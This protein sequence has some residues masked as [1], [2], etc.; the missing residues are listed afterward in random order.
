MLH[1]QGRRRRDSNSKPRRNRTRHKYLK[2]RQLCLEELEA[3]AMLTG[4]W[5]P[6]TNLAP[7]APV[8]FALLSDGSVIQPGNGYRLTPDATGS[9]IN[10]TWS[11]SAGFK[12]S[13]RHGASL[14]VLPDGRLMVFGGVTNGTTPTPLGDGE[15]FDAVTGAATNMASFPESGS[16]VGPSV[17]P[18]ML[19]PNGDVL[20]G[21]TSDPN[22]YI[23][24]PV[25][26]AYESWTL[27]PNGSILSYD[28]NGKPGEA[29]RLD[30]TT[31]TWVDAGAVPVALEAGISAYKDMGPGVL[32]PNGQ[33]LQFGRSSQTAIY[34][35]PTPG[36]G[37]NG[38][39]SWA[40][41]PVIPNGLEAGGENPTFAGSAAA[42]LPSGDVLFTADMPD[43]VGPTKFFEWNPTTNSVTDVTPPIASYQSNSANSTI[44]ML[45]LPTGQVLLGNQTDQQLYVYTPGGSPQAAW[46]PTITS[47]VANGDH[48]TLTGTQLNGI[49]AGVSHGVST[50]MATNFPIVE[51]KDSSGVVYLARTSNWSNTGVATGK[52]AMSTDFTLPYY[53]PADT[54]SLTV[55]A[56][57]ISSDPTPFQLVV[58]PAGDF[59]LDEQVTSADVPV[60]LAALSDLNAF[61]QAHTLSAPQLFALGDLNGDHLVNNADLQWLLSKLRGTLVNAVPQM[62]ID[63]DSAA[64]VGS[65]PED[66]LTIGT[67]TYFTAD[68]GIH[69][70]ELWKTDGTAAGTV[71]VKDINPD[72]ES[73][74]PT[75]LTVFN[76]EL[77]FAADDGVDGNELWKSDGTEAGTVMVADIQPGSGYDS[78]SQSFVPYSSNP[79]Y[80]TVAGGT[81]FFAAND[82]SNGVELWKTD[83][84]EQGTVLVKDIDT[85]IGYGSYPS[86][87]TDV[88]GTLFFRAYDSDNGDE[89]WKSDGTEAGTVLVKDIYPG[90]YY[91]TRFKA[92]YPNSSFPY[93]LTAVGGTLYFTAQDG[94]HGWELWESDGTEAGT[95]L[96][97]DIDP[98]PDGFP[99]DLHALNGKL[100]FD[101][102]DGQ[103]GYELWTSDGTAAGTQ[104]VKDIFP[105][106]S[107]GFPGNMRVVNGTLYFTAYQATGT[108]RDAELWKSDGT[109]DGT[110]RIADINPGLGSSFPY[111]F[112]QLGNTIYF[113]ADDGTHGTELWKT[114]GTPAGTTLVCDINPGSPESY[115]VN[116]T[117]L[118]NSLLFTADDGVHGTELW[119]LTPGQTVGGSQV[120]TF[121]NDAESLQTALPGSSSG[122]DAVV[123]SGA[124]QF[125]HRSERKAVNHFDFYRHE[126]AR[127]DQRPQAPSVEPG[128]KSDVATLPI[129]EPT[130]GTPRRNVSTDSEVNSFA[131]VEASG[132]GSFLSSVNSDIQTAATLSPKKPTSVRP[133]IDVDVHLALSTFAVD[134]VLSAGTRHR[135]RH[136]LHTGTTTVSFTTT[137]DEFDLESTRYG[138]ALHELNY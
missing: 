57:G 27:L 17:G 94:N 16:G 60:M 135:A 43:I 18:S 2:P 23:F 77:Y 5:T 134:Q 4:T 3:R 84:T 102:N 132:A 82:G 28:V 137:D 86:Y 109:T 19:L 117:V 15:I 29:Q 20:V 69:G 70:R 116:L 63:I 127:I 64:A 81:L 90:T 54:Y 24:D 104:L 124:P 121:V 136:A 71:M 26:N 56:N 107:D 105:G 122:D 85:A 98:G 91:D 95:Q 73:S 80:L 40:A 103:T 42:L 106:S 118:G 111:D 78:N 50:Q 110:V 30:P 7:G 79:S 83:G 76:G 31:M 39:G 99:T 88:N 52:L 87:L 8:R 47:V 32:M 108:N 53:V 72:K 34:T 89:L 130:L 100:V 11:T 101:A 133:P 129:V 120:S 74:D 126:L 131:A 45:V 115:P 55:I 65:A 14:L 1:S 75:Y 46:Q 61:Q 113:Q 125:T 33:V 96:V 6:L 123:S 51:L 9:Y 68:D 66:L 114:D 67:T 119:K 62:V 97:K 13:A 41:G 10:G 25:A 44:R 37:T 21:S 138:S 12:I 128:V 112:T 59:N 38:V 93:Y 48:L 22:T 92:T 58:P 35:P 49:S 36:D